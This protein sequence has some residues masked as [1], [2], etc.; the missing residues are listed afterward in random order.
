[1]RVA[2]TRA[3]VAKPAEGLSFR[4]RLHMALAMIRTNPSSA[5]TF[6]SVAVATFLLL[7]SFA[8]IN[9]MASL[10]TQSARDVI[11][12]DVSVFADGYD[13]SMLNPRA[14][15]VYYLND[16]AELS[17]QL[18][19]T[20]LVDGVRSRIN[21]GAQLS[22]AESDVGVLVI[23]ANF[24][25]EGY[26]LLEGDEPRAVG[27]ICINPTQRDDLGLAVGDTVT[28]AVAGAPL[29]SQ[30]VEATV[31]CVYDNGRF[32]LFRSTHVIMRLSDLQRILD[33]PDVATQLLLDLAPGIGVAD[34]SDQL[35]QRFAQVRFL[36]ADETADLIFIIQTAQRAVMWALV[37][38]TAIICGILVGNVVGFALRRERGEIATMRTMGFDAGSLRVI[39][40]MQTLIVGTVM[41]AI[42]V[43]LALIGI[44]VTGAI[45]IPLGRAE[46]LFGD[47]TLRPWLGAFDI[48]ITAV[49]MLGAL[50]VTNLLATRGM[51]RRPPVEIAREP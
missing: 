45:G 36:T 49:L 12:G 28:L 16:E 4:Y 47:D 51:L 43:G 33:R 26:K 31:S 42:G 38:V 18:R 30:P 6:I 2:Q 14:D 1:M 7:V 19:G 10:M 11:S 20:G 34:A 25:A 29:G 37:A 50:G 44:W 48:V 21:A 8:A 5:R 24:A 27:E 39:Y 41:I 3:V 40:A 15:V 23:G 46:Q 17:S 35:A 22:T 9:A 32:G 13:Y